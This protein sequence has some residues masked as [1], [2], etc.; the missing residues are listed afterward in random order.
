MSLRRAAVA[1][2]FY[3]ADPATLRAQIEAMI[4]PDPKPALGVLVP[5]A[6][7]DYSGAVA[8][9][10]LSRVA[11]TRDVVLLSFNHRAQ[12]PKLSIWSEGAWQTP[13]GQVP[14]ATELV[15]RLRGLAEPDEAPFLREHSGEVQ[16]P[17]LQV[18]RPDVRI[19]PL[20]VDSHDREAIAVFAHGLA[21]AGGDALVVATTDLTH[22]G[23]SYAA[24][25]PPGKSAREWAREQDAAVLETIRA[26]DV[27]A[28]WRV[29]EERHVT[30]CGVA[31]TAA[32]ITY[33]RA[34]GAKS[35]EIVKYATSADDEP[36]ADRAVG[37]PGVIVRTHVET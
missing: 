13:L 3:P 31:P 1:G 15:D 20:S 28:F 27:D 34:R 36:D 32:L 18:L 30:M 9:A 19:A 14:I 25:A 4:R 22:C 10:A 35:A 12:R 7:Y 26:L 17:L 37:Y 6:G 23:E 8:G 16:V 33:A 24:P 21:R 11:V 29:V 5:H 2:A